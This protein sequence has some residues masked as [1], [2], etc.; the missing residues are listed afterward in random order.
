[1]TM[2]Y[3]WPDD[4]CLRAALTLAVRAPSVHNTQPW[5]FR[6]SERAV[7]LYLDPTWAHQ[8]SDFDQRDVVL[9]CGAVLHHLRVALAASGWS[10]V[11][12]RLPN[13]A[14]PNCLA[15]IE[16]VP[17]RPTM[18]DS[19]LGN[20]I[21]H[22]QTDRRNFSSAP[23]P[24]GYLGLVN[25]RATTLG[26]SVRQAVDTARERLVEALRAATVLDSAEP[27][28][29]LELANWSGRPTTPGGLPARSIPLRSDPDGSLRP[30]AAAPHAGSGHEP[31]FA[32]LLVLAT[33]GDDRLAQ[34]CAGEALSAVLL[35]ATNV[36]LATCVLTDP[37]QVPELRQRIRVGVLDGRGYPQAVIRIGWTADA[38][39]LPF[40]PRHALGDVLERYEATA[41]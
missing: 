7:Q 11:V 41:C 31:D 22:R 38:A 25:E 26:A 4:H 12:R 1:M 16:L 6:I 13:A 5:R 28:Y 23:I 24:P 19:A 30:V 35:T 17:H 15:S 3:G 29:R 40:T 10:A 14:N 18:L 9:S 27:Q 32:E 39:A 21:P 20:A 34:L 33:S 36:G 37:L 8:P 2:N